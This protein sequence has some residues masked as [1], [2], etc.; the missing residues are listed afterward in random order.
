MDPLLLYWQDE[1]KEL[2]GRIYTAGP[3]QEIYCFC[4]LSSLIVSE[5]KSLEAKQNTN[6][7]TVC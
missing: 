3:S 2:K 7:L 5:L 4:I 6:L 1:T